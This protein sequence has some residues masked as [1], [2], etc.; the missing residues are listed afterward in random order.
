MT[1]MLSLIGISTV[2]GLAL[3][4]PARGQD[5][6]ASEPRVEVL[7][8][9]AGVGTRGPAAEPPA[10]PAV[11]LAAGERVAV[12]V[13][14]GVEVGERDAG[15]GPVAD[16]AV[17]DVIARFGSSG[18]FAW[19]DEPTVWVAPEGG[20][21]TF[22]VNA[23]PAH[24]ARGAARIEVL[25]LGGLDSP[26]PRGFEPPILQL[27]RVPGGAR[28]RWSDRAG[29]GVEPATLFLELTTSHGT[30]YRLDPWVRPGPTEV[31]LP[32]P[33]PGLSLPPGIHTV[34]ATIQDRLGVQSPPSTIR[35][36]TP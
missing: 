32:L 30:V 10:S 11:R 21:L 19:P 14:E 35:F 6:G 28:A 25:R 5:G 26:A 16:A 4:V 7:V 20:T 13:E 31:T 8:V 24:R 12:R 17:G 2:A 9:P 22:D 3:V 36:D 27:D 33:P 1:Q 15:P 18:A 29:Y 23:Y 34:T